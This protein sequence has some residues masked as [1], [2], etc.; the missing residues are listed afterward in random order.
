MKEKRY[1]FGVFVLC[2]RTTHYGTV[3]YECLKN[4]DMLCDVI[5]Y[6]YYY[7]TCNNKFYLLMSRKIVVNTLYDISIAALP[8]RRDRLPT[9]V[10][11]GFPGGLVSKESTC[12]E[13]D[14]VSVPGLGRP[15]GGGHGDP[16]QYF[17]LENPHGQRSLVGSSPWGR[18]ELDT[19][20]RPSTAQHSTRCSFHLALKCIKQLNQ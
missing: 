10:F 3:Q 20:G 5:Y 1:S 16:L 11:L 13:G 12:N 17:C 6:F 14:M 4:N 2:P 15:S 7:R 18:K 8:L 19:T 9:P